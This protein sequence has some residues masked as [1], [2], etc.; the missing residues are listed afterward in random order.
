[1]IPLPT[2]SG[3]EKT[4]PSVQNY[5]YKD[6]FKNINFHIFKKIIYV[7]NTRTGQASDAFLY[8]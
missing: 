6:R 2:K 5:H 8:P 1:V 4:P 3:C 7:G